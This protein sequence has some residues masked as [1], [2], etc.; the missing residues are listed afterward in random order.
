MLIVTARNP[1]QESYGSAGYAEVR[2]APDAG[3]GVDGHR[4]VAIDDPADMQSMGLQAV[5]ADQEGIQQMIR[6]AAQR[7]PALVSSI[8]LAGGTSVL[9]FVSLQNPVTDP[10]DPDP[11]VLSDNPYG[12]VANSLQEQLAPSRPVG[13]I[14]VPDNA[15][16]DEFVALV[17]GFPHRYNAPAVGQPGA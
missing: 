1:L 9:P 6:A 13:R 5:T 15:S 16:L 14:P 7:Y 4:V 11:E 2:A 17:Q 3:A 12:A 8:L 10:T